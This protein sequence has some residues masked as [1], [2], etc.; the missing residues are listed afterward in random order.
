MCGIAGYYYFNGRP[1]A[2]SVLTDFCDVIRHRGPDE[3]GTF[4][5]DGIGLGIRR[6]RVIDLS[7]GS[8]PMSNESG[9][10]TVVF[11]GEIYNFESIRRDLVSSGHR[12]KSHSDTEVIVHAYEEW[13]PGCVSRFAGMFAFALWDQRARQ[14]MLARDP[15]GIKPLYY[16]LDDHRLLFGSELKVLAQSPDFAPSVKSQSVREYF[17]FGMSLAPDTIFESTYQLRPGTYCLVDE[18]GNLNEQS[19]WSL[20]FGNGDE[21]RTKDVVNSLLERLDASV[22]EHLISDVPLGAFLSGGVDSSAILASAQQG[23]STPMQAFSVGFSEAAY[24]ESVYAADISD[25]LG[26]DFSALRVGPEDLT[27]LLPEIAWYYDEPF[28]DPST[29]PTYF[30]SRATRQHVTVAL[31]G[32]GGDE[33]FAGYDQ[34]VAERLNPL[35]RMMP[36]GAFSLLGRLG[37][38]GDTGESTAHRLKRVHEHAKIDGTVRRFLQKEMMFDDALAQRLLTPEFSSRQFLGDRAI[39]L[40]DSVRSTGARNATEELIAAHTLFRLPNQMLVK[41]DRASMAN[42]LEVRVPF[43]DHRIVDYAASLN[44]GL[45]L[46]GLTTK[47]ILKRALCRR[48]PRSHVYRRKRGFEAPLASWFRGDLAEFTRQRLLDPSV[49]REGLFNPQAVGAVL[50][51]HLDG[52]YDHSH[53]IY[54]MLMYVLWL[55]HFRKSWKG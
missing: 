10:V 24:D 26:T 4:I 22:K 51:E 2:E 8:Q 34:F 32:D 49:E 42:S 5:E 30:L 55:G 14:L 28:A 39:Q 53:A 15:L 47:S 52:K 54:G 25:H 35:V 33:V 23:S 7:S 36:S 48:V 29:V 3:A 37:G 12:F 45:K 27:S 16:T 6:L 44:S 1:P 17:T 38:F 11:N 13:G 50:S 40:Q 18:A 19:Y 9:D 21:P 46:R 31:S 20:K 41:V 43:L